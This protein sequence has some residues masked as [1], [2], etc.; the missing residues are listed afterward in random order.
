MNGTTVQTAVAVVG[1][2]TPRGQRSSAVATSQID[3][4]TVTGPITHPVKPG[5]TIVIKERWF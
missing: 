3:G 4:Q 1:E 5:D 2:F